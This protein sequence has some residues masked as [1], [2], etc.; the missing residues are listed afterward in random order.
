MVTGRVVEY[1]RC[2][3]SHAVSKKK[4]HVR[5]TIVKYSPRYRENFSLSQHPINK[6]SCSC[7]PA[8]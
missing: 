2:S 3:V 6:V 4:Y 5:V 1:V 8:E 7:Q